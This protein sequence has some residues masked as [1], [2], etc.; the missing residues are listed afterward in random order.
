MDMRLVMNRDEYWQAH[1][2]L[3]KFTGPLSLALRWA[4]RKGPGMH[5]L[6]YL[7]KRA[8]ETMLGMMDEV[9]SVLFLEG[10]DRW[11]GSVFED[12]HK[13]LKGKDP[14]I[15]TAAV[16]LFKPEEL[17]VFKELPDDERNTKIQETWKRHLDS[18]PEVEPKKDTKKKQPS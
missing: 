15:E 17:K 1:H 6:L 4:D 7:C 8:E 5:M 14:L 2:M 9:N 12:M 10:D 3:C 13:F 11:K 16:K 18:F